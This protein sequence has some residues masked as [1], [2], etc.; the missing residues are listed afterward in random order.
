VPDL[1]DHVTSI[2]SR[3][4][5][6]GEW[7]AHERG[8]TQ[9]HKT[10]RTGQLDERATPSGLDMVTPKKK[11][12]LVKPIRVSADRLEQQMA[13]VEAVEAIRS[14]TDVPLVEWLRCTGLYLAYKHC[15]LGE[16]AETWRKTWAWVKRRKDRTLKAPRDALR[17]IDALIA[18]TAM[19]DAR[20][21]AHAKATGYWAAREKAKREK[22][23]AKYKA[24]ARDRQRQCRARKR[25][26]Q[27]E[28][29]Y[30]QLAREADALDV[31]IAAI[32]ATIRSG[33][34]LPL[35]DEIPDRD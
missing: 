15:T 11:R 16:D 5:V 33:G 30:A 23:P 34:A 29:V 20:W 17:V 24:A 25:E 6:R 32:V 28:A 8:E 22:D 18:Y 9:D 19:R 35:E 2:V 14:R 31:E 26:S 13:F 3:A 12:K 1:G 7:P 10:E 4:G 21:R 27:Q